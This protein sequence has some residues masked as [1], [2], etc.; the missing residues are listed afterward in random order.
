[1]APPKARTLIQT[2]NLTLRV[3]R[4]DDSTD[5]IALERDPDVMRFLTGGGDAAALGR[6]FEDSYLKPR[7]TE[8]YV[9]TARRTGTGSFVG[10]FCLWPEDET[11]ADLGYRLRRNEWGKGLASE[12]A[13]ALV[14]WGFSIAGYD[15]IIASTMTVNQASRRVLEKCGLVL[16]RTV[17]IDW[18][19][20]I[21]GGDQGE[22]HYELPRT[23]WLEKQG[24]KGNP[25]ISR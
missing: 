25:A 8:P 17:P 4:P 21:P 16:A 23:R 11:S 20:H 2:G 19:G 24:Q 22:V 12:G 3:C 13:S 14:D 1:M 7:G 9:W 5:F 18:A 15:K 6:E 10:W